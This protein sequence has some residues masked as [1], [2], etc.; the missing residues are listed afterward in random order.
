VQIFFI[1]SQHKVIFSLKSHFL[2]VATSDDDPALGTVS[3]LLFSKRNAPLNGTRIDISRQRR[4]E[5]SP[6]SNFVWQTRLAGNMEQ[7]IA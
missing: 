7:R 2:S 6:C 5:K 1:R 4:I 3:F